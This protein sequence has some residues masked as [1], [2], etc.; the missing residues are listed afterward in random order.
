MKTFKVF[1]V[2]LVTCI[3]V[4]GA[5]PETSFEC[6]YNEKEDLI[7]YREYYIGKGEERVYHGLTISIRNSKRKIGSTVTVNKEIYKEGKLTSSSNA[8][9]T[10]FS[11]EKFGLD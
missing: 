3:A 9:S 2:L 11:T 10:V 1:A 6:S 8:G 4:F 7:T 5:D